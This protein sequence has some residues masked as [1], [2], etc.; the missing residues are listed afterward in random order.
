M[1]ETRRSHKKKEQDSIMSADDNHKS[2]DRME[3]EMVSPLPPPP[4]QLSETSNGNDADL[5]KKNKVEGSNGTNNHV[6]SSQDEKGKEDMTGHDDTTSNF[7]ETPILTT[8]SLIL[9]A[10]ISYFTYPD[11]LQPVG[12]PTLN[13]VWYFGWISALSTGLGVL[14]LIFSPRLDTWWVGVTNAIAAGMMM[15]ASYSLVMEGIT[16][17]EKE[18]SSS[19]SPLLR[20]AIG[21]CLG[22]LFILSTKSF[23]EKHEELKVAGLAGADARKVLLIIFVMTLHSFS[24][25]IGIGVSFGGSNGSELGVFISASLAIHNVPEGLAVAIVL[26]PRKISK[27]TAALWCIVTSLPQ[28]LMAVPAFLFV[29]AFIPFL[30]VGLGFAGGAMAWVAL[31]ELLMEAIEDTNVLTTGLF[32][33]ISLGVMLKMQDMIDQG[34]RH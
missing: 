8:V 15:A 14:P 18:D 7:V 17:T 9:I 11:S 13:H 34:S 3:N 24:E 33:S 16:F 1:V 4:S 27:L 12:R 29:H 25:G 21:S 30:P 26:L 28:P 5:I 32:S 19:I 22:L 31:F 23:L 20:T 10:L 6:V 2:T